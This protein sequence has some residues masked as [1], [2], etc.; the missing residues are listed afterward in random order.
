MSTGA[1]GHVPGSGGEN[2]FQGTGSAAA[3]R[4]TSCSAS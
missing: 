3:Q 2:G 1:G 4:T